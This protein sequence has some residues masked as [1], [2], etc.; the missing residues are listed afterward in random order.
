MS[1]KW[2]IKYAMEN[3]S[4]AGIMKKK[5]KKIGNLLALHESYDDDDFS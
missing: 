3:V 1:K 2:Y 5:K 4:E